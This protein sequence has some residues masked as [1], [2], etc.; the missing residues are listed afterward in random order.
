MTL[1]CL[2]VLYHIYKYIF[3]L[4]HVDDIDLFAG[5]VS[6]R[7]ADGGLVGPTFGCIIADHFRSIRQ[8]DRY[9]FENGGHQAFT[10]GT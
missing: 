9:W 5:G 4:S 10:P 3:H 2:V 8:G 1:T 7:A 6:E